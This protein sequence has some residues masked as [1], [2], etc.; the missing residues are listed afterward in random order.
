[1]QDIRWDKG[2]P[3]PVVFYETGNKRKYFTYIKDS[4]MQLKEYSFKLKSFG[5]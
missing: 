4:C 3:E 5:F 2:G 1:V